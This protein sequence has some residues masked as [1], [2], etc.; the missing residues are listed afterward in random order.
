MTSTPHNN[1]V[2]ADTSHTPPNI[3]QPTKEDIKNFNS[4]FKHSQ[5]N[6]SST[7]QSEPSQSPHQKNHSSTI[8]FSSKQSLNDLLHDTGIYSAPNKSIINC[9]CFKNKSSPALRLFSINRL[10]VYNQV[11][12]S[13]IYHEIILKQ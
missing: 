10:H 4:L 13:L 12:I 5:S 7:S 8:E 3:I 6:K 9:N 2:K 1:H 11:K